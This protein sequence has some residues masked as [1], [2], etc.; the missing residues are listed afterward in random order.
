MA[1]TTRDVI[2]VELDLGGYPVILADTAGLRPPGDALEEEGIRRARA[3]AATA[4]LRLVVVDA[5]APEEVLAVEPYLGPGAILVA[6]K[7]DLAAPELPSLPPS[8]VG[9]H[10]VPVSVLT[11]EGM[12]DLIEHLTE[13]V[14]EMMT[15]ESASV[16]TRSRHRE[17]LE[18]SR[19]ALERFE[20]ARLPELAAEDLRAAARSL[21]R[22]TGRVDVEDILDALFKEFCIGK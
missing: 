8:L 1:G 20:E 12:S 22:I 3:R 14:S 10:A 18:A 9:E 21:G 11:G 4:D 7:I 13:K 16:V 17:A 2:E 5:S 15:A 19:L 6:N